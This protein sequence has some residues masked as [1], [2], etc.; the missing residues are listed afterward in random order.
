MKT[1][2][3]VRRIDDLG[4]IVIP[5][6]VR[7]RLKIDSGDLV[8]IYVDDMN[9]ILTKFHPLDHDSQIVAAFCD[10]LKTGY[11]VDLIVTN[12]HRV[13]YSTKSEI[14]SDDE[15]D[16]DFLKRINSYLQ[17]EVSPLNKINITSSYCID[18]DAII[19]QISINHEIYGYLIILDDMISKKQKDIAAFVLDYLN[20]ILI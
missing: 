1:T 17:K 2:G 20:K 18:K 14:K 6:E 19:Y 5:K 16:E 10:S 9:V 8:D 11:N 4:R 7:K 15:L 12:M 13:I 3:I